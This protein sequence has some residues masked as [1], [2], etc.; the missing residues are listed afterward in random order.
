MAALPD[1]T[2]PVWEKE[3]FRQATYPVHRLTRS[4]LFEWLDK[5]WRLGSVMTVHRFGYAP[6]DLTFAVE[7]CAAQLLRYYSGAR[8]ARMT[9]AEL[10]AGAKIAPHIDNGIGITAVHRIHVPIVTN[11]DVHFFIDKVSHYLEAGI[12]YEFD[13]TR[14]H[15]VENRSTERR[16]HLMCDLM[17]ASLVV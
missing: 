16:V 5:E 17:P 2:D 4:I 12:I 9:L 14:L 8:L 10:P 1:A 11:P 6:A 7:A 15:A 3:P 13:N